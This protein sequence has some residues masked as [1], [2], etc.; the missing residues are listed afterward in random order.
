MPVICLTTKVHAPIERVFDLARSIDMHAASMDKHGERAVAGV[1]H[2]LIDL[3]EEVTWQAKHFGVR[4]RLTSRITIFERPRRFRDSMIKGAFKRFDHDHY[5]EQYGDHTIMT[6]FFDYTAPLGLL[7]YIAD[8]L[9]LKAYMA[10]LLA[11]RNE[12]VKTVAESDAWR[13]YL[14]PEGISG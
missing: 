2:G 1:T 7:G 12:I 14:P 10:R 8:A 6:E 4:Q 3:G 9:F 5:F 13:A 11:G